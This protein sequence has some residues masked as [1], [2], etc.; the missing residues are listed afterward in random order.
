MTSPRLWSIIASEEQ[1]ESLL[2]YCPSNAKYI[3][4]IIASE[5][6]NESLLLFCPNDAS[7]SLI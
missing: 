5:E 6:Q 7:I 4:D 2:S 1:Y 3:P